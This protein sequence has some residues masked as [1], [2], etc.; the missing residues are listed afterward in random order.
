MLAR[1]EEGCKWALLI[2]INKYKYPEIKP[3]F[4]CVNDVELMSK[5]LQENFEFPSNQITVLQDE[6]ATREG[7]LVTMDTLVN[8]VGENDIVVIHYSGHGSQMTDRE[9]DEKDGLDETIVPHDSGRSPNPNR[10]ITDDEIYLR[11][12]RLSEKTPHITLVFDC[13]HSG[14][15]SRDPFGVSERWVEPDLRPIEELP[16]SLV[17]AELGRG[18]RDSGPSGW[19][20]LSKCYVLIA[21][22]RDE[23]RAYEYISR[24]SDSQISHG[25][26][27]YFL[28]QGLRSA[29]PGTTYRDIFEWVSPQVSAVRSLQHPQMEGARDRL[30]FDTEE[31]EPMRFVSVRERTDYQVTLGA[32]AAHGMTL[33][34]QWAIYPSGTKQIT[35]ETPKLGLVEITAVGAVTCDAQILEESHES[36]IV[37][38]TRALE[39]AHSYGQ[40]CLKVGIQAP[41]GYETA[42]RELMDLISVSSLI[43]TISTGETAD[44]R[45]YLIPPRTEVTEG[46]AVPQLGVATQSTWVVVGKD[47]QLIVPPQVVT[48]TGAAKVVRDNLEKVV[49][50]RQTLSLQNPNP[51]CLLKDKVKFILKRQATDGSWEVAEPE[52]SSGQIVFQDG[53]QIALEIINHHDAPIYIGILDFG[54]TGAVSLLHPVEGSNEQLAPEKSIEIGIRY[55][56]EIQLSI[57]PD[58][59]FVPVTNNQRLFGETETFKLLVTTRET[60]F[61]IRVQESFESR[62][63][64]DNPFRQLLDVAWMGDNGRDAI[65][66]RLLNHRR[67]EE[68][69]ITVERSFFLKVRTPLIDSLK[70]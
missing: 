5:I 56:D 40:M 25:A 1:T 13:C 59:P 66:S 64:N 7:I 62:Q 69:W 45:I 37:T 48:N 17:L 58:F 42:V 44:A 61:S 10:D 49:R 33:G 51:N 27:T 3:L 36:A 43:Q 35:A 50:Y 53:E 21:A 34:S 32:G 28:G 57:P 26:L 4:G 11:L 12:L 6:E 39:E 31:I 30:L 8:S 67:P 14:T 16:P 23:E 70:S 38:G 47:G 55:G 22:C 54:L 68:E 41:I 60:D 19:L 9:G 65:R 52:N 63:V 24:Q 20:P 2:G 46:D 18:M 29:Q 15:I